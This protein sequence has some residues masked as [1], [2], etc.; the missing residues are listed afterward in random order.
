MDNLWLDRHPHRELRL[1]NLIKPYFDYEVTTT[2]N[3]R[4][5]GSGGS[6]SSRNGA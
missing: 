5:I 2:N 6:R 1:P 4:F 3:R